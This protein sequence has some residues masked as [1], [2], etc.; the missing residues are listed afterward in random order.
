MKQLTSNLEYQD[1]IISSIQ[2]ACQNE[3][4]ECTYIIDGFEEKI[5]K[6][7]R[8]G[9]F[10]RQNVEIS[11]KVLTTRSWSDKT[12][13]Q[14]DLLQIS[15]EEVIS[16]AKFIELT[17]ELMKYK[18]FSSE[19][20]ASLD[21]KFIQVYFEYD[22]LEATIISG[23]QFANTKVQDI[24]D[25]YDLK[26]TLPD[27]DCIFGEEMP[28]WLMPHIDAYEKFQHSMKEKSYIQIGGHGNWIQGSYTDTYIAQVNNE[29]GDCG[30]VFI[31]CEDNEFK[32]W[33]DMY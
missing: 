30:A 12:A 33:V 24:L 1:K 16:I 28:E 10:S 11:K 18:I 14:N 21:E 8:W 7:L 25:A 26:L 27:Y 5:L 13:Y 2:K 29:V 32:D 6:N 22:T 3:L 17:P 4:L 31:V 15:F 23:K 19:L 20:Q 9:L